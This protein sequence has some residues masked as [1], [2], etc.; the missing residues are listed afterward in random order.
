MKK[1]YNVKTRRCSRSNSSL[2]S[3]FTSVKLLRVAQGA[4][5]RRRGSSFFGKMPPTTFA[6]AFWEKKVILNP[7]IFPKNFQF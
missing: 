7:T 6:R 3:M 1:G 2:T 4:A 5:S